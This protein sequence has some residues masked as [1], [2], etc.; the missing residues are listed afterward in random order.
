M[1]AF[2][3]RVPRSQSTRG[4]VKPTC[5]MCAID[6]LVCVCAGNVRLGIF[7]GRPDGRMVCEGTFY[8][9]YETIVRHYSCLQTAMVNDSNNNLLR[10]QQY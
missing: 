10:I 5:R 3:V 6:F 9:K 7:N 2:S 4:V 1:T 8:R